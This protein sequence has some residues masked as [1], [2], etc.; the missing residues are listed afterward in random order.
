METESAAVLAST[1]KEAEG[2]A[3]R[4]AF[5]DGELM[6]VH[7]A[8]D[9][10][11]VNSQNLSGVVADVDR[12]WEEDERECLERVQELTLLQ[13]RGSEL[14]QAIVGP[15]KVRGHLS[16]G[17]WITIIHHIK[18]VEQLPHSRW[19]CLPLLSPCLNDLPLKPSGWRLWMRWY[20]PLLSPCLNAL[21][22]REVRHQ[23]L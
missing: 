16:E 21:T 2:S 9:M 10:A 19:W 23:S 12:R 17:M 4:I 8:R 7:E 5:L 22:P 11:Q 15:P 13:T 1:C 3:R 14:C 6:D 18:M 20:L